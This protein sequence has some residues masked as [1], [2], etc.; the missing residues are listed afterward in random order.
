MHLNLSLRLTYRVTGMSAPASLARLGDFPISALGAIGIMVAQ[1]VAGRALDSSRGGTTRCA[2]TNAQRSRCR[3]RRSMVSGRNLARSAGVGK[4][5]WGRRTAQ[6]VTLQMINA[7][8][9]PLTDGAA[10]VLVGGHGG[11]PSGRIR[12]EKKVK[13]ASASRGRIHA[14]G[15]VTSRIWTTLIEIGIFFMRLSIFRKC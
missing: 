9:P 15:T 2:R 10:K 14:Y 5:G 4:G 13:L 12:G 11:W 3:R 8:E 1:V 6:M 7:G